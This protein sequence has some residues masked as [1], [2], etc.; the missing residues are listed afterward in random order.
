MKGKQKKACRQGT[1]RKLKQ[2]GNKRQGQKTRHGVC[3]KP[4]EPTFIA[5]PNS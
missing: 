2:V 1:V 5:P 3:M 4:I